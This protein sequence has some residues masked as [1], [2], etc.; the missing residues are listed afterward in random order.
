MKADGDMD[1]SISA[2]MR[3]VLAGDGVALPGDGS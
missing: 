2:L 1:E 3:W